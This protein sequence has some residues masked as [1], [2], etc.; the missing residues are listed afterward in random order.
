MNEN[1]A[2]VPPEQLPPEPPQG[3]ADSDLAIS[4]RRRWLLAGAGFLGW[5]I[6]N[7]LFWLIYKQFPFLDPAGIYGL[8]PYL[9]MAMLATVINVVLLIVLA[10]IRR[11][12][13]IAL[14]ILAAWALNFAISL[15][16]GLSFNGLC[17]TP[18]F[19][20]LK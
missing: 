5:Y 7:G 13:W 16:L 6:V 12:R 10:L 19:T 17:L 8:S 4:K 14:G 20:P 9:N 18:F 1:P 2:P 3:P 15:V 11:T